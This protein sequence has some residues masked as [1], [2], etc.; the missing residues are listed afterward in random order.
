[1]MWARQRSFRRW[2]RKNDGGMT[3]SAILSPGAISSDRSTRV[4]RARC[5]NPTFFN[6]LL[7]A[8]LSLRRG[9]A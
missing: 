1:M 9:Q 6:G 4:G 3:R 8:R 2:K 7:R 5:K